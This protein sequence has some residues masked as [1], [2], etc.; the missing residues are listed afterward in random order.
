[1]G[2]AEHL[3]TITHRTQI[4]L[5]YRLTLAVLNCGL[6]A[7]AAVASTRAADLSMAGSDAAV[8]DLDTIRSRF[9]M[10]V[11]PTDP[12]QTNR[13]HTLSS[14]YSSSLQLNG[15]WSDINYG[16]SARPLWP[17]TD[18]LQRILVMAKSARL[19]RNAGHP[20][21]ALEQKT[22]LA[23]RWWISH[24]YQ[25][26]LNGALWWWNQ[27]GVPELIGE[28]ANLMWSDLSAGDISKIAEIMKRSDWK[29]VPWTGANLTW[30]VTNEIV[31]GCIE[32]DP[33]T[34]AEGYN[35]L[36]QEIKIV[37]PTEEGIEQDDSFHQHGTQLYNGGYGLSYANDVGRFIAFA[38]GTRF[39]IPPD[40]MAIFSSYL[41]D[42]EQWMVRGDVIDY[43]VLGREITRKEM[44]VAPGDWTVGPISPAG[45]A[46]SLPNVVA[47][48]AAESIPRRQDFQNFAAR[49]RGSENMS[50]FTGNKQFWCSDFMTHRRKAFYTSVKML[51]KRIQNAEITNGEGKKSEHLS[52]GV[53]FLYLTGDE[54]KDIFPVWD[55]TK[56]PGTTAIQGTLDTGEKDRISAH[57]TTTFDGGV[58]DGT[59]G[60]AAMELHRG[61]LNAKKAWFFFDDSYLCLGAGITTTDDTEHSVATDVNQTLLNS[62][63]FT[64][65]SKSPVRSGVYSYAA[66][67]SAWAF[68]D[69]VGYVF[70]PGT[71]LNLSVGSQTGRWSDIGDGIGLDP[72]V[73]ADQLVTHPVF[74]LW[75]DHGRSPQDS[76]YQYIV[77]PGATLKETME[78]ATRPTIRVL[79]NTEDIQAAWDGPLG[80]AMIAFRRPGSL[81]TPDG[82]VA[83]D[84][85]CLLLIRRIA[86]GWKISAANPENMPLV[87][88][89]KVQNLAVTMDL[90]GGNFAGSSV[91]SVVRSVR[92]TTIH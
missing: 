68:H 81:A 21:D 20:D 82:N 65:Q 87:L 54:Y 57:G 3:K 23:L 85:S 33:A 86:G 11:L 43:S 72:G 14:R 24:D 90:P 37:G 60:L 36:Y 74:N 48:L 89:V 63:V 30:G 78:R 35:R 45:P 15:S 62:P 17:A 71:H 52:D 6:L 51:S 59:Y 67:G 27:I 40:R 61:N 49:L 88:H 5:A 32:N 7:H 39:Q 53:N 46:Y 83:V 66:E 13:L 38:W 69:H 9:A 47:M 10:S 1:M 77:L 16:D 8:S 42:G 34:V 56:L 80:I 84:H 55:W 58:S 79:A 2:P 73:S 76:T 44:V 75:I 22:I 25:D 50:A 64:S 29:H 91:T 12:I 26:H 92:V 18:H 31:R 70:A 19:Y 4:K 41:L 28:S